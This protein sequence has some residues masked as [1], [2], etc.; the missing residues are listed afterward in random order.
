MPLL[1]LNFNHF[2]LCLAHSMIAYSQI[3]FQE[4]YS[5]GNV[6]WISFF[7]THPSCS[8]FRLMRMGVEA[9]RRH[10][11]SCNK[12]QPKHA[13]HVLPSTIDYFPSWF[14]C[15]MIVQ[16]SIY[17]VGRVWHVWCWCGLHSFVLIHLFCGMW[18]HY[19]KQIG[20]YERMWSMSM[21]HMAYPFYQ[22]D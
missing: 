18:K 3:A 7:H 16:W 22:L 1:P 8:V 21:S 14:T 11:S 20:D 2:P 4:G 5:V 10:A 15:S 19:T 6:A 13:M 17:F 12:Q 9:P